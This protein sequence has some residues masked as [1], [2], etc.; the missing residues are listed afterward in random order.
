MR[1]TPP[2]DVPAA[3]VASYLLAPDHPDGRGKALFF[4]RLGFQRDDPE[5]LADALRNHAIEHDVVRIEMSPFGERFVVE[6]P[7][8][9][10]DGRAPRVRAIWFAA[11][12]GPVRLVTAYPLSP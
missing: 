3:K 12:G 7:L 9:T 6:G 11:A 8:A 4:A 5:R 1:L 10:P 2:F